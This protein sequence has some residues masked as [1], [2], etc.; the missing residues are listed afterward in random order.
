MHVKRGA[1]VA[2]DE[3]VEQEEEEERAGLEIV[4]QGQRQ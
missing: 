3:G 1:H 4:C 2:K